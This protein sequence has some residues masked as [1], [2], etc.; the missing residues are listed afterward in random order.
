PAQRRGARVA[1]ALPSEAA[2]RAAI[3]SPG[4]SRGKPRTAKPQATFDT[5]AGANAVTSV[6]V[7]SITLTDGRNQI[8][9]KRAIEIVCRTE[10]PEIGRAHL[11]SSHRTISY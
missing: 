11:N 6:S 2:N 7:M 3:S 4:E 5:V 8:I 10:V 9:A 1:T